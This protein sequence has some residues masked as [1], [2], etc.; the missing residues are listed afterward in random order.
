MKS[1]SEGMKMRLPYLS[2]R[3][4]TASN[5][6]YETD[7]PVHASELGSERAS[8][9]LEVHVRADGCHDEGSERQVHV[10]ETPVV[11]SGKRSSNGGTAR[12]VSRSCE[13]DS[14]MI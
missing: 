5:I 4:S 11:G 2:Q 14:G 10:E 12:S 1:V 9:R 7:L 6:E 13:D 3:V 8:R